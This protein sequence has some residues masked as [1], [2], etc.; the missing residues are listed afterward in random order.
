MPV[1][2]PNSTHT[3]QSTPR[4]R[5]WLPW[6]LLGVA[7]IAFATALFVL[8]P[9]SLWD[10]LTGRPLYEGRGVASWSKQ[11][12]STDS[13]A[14]A[15]AIFALSALGADAAS[16]VPV[17]ASI[18]EQDDDDNLRNQAAFALG[19]MA[20]ASRDAVPALAGAL[21]DANLTVRMTAAAALA[22]L[23][24]EAR[25]AIPALLEA[26]Q[27]DSNHTNLGKFLLTI[28]EMLVVALGRA[29][30]GTAE[31]VPALVRIVQSDDSEGLRAAA[32]R[33]LGEVGEEAR[34]TIPLLKTLL[35]DNSS[36]VRE[37][38]Q[39]ALEQLGEPIDELVAVQQSADLELPESERAW[40]WQVEN[41]GNELV[42]HGFGPLAQALEKADRQ[43]LSRLLADTFVGSDLAQVQSARLQRDFAEISRQRHSKTAQSLDRA[44]FVNRLLE[45][46]GRFTAEAP[47]VGL[48]LK[49]L[50][51][52]Q[53]EQLNGAWQGTAQMRLAGEFTTDKPGEIVVQLRFQL[54]QLTRQA[55]SK[56]GWL[57][58]VTIDEVTMAGATHRLFAEVA[59]QRGLQVEKLHDNWNAHKHAPVTGGI[60]V[61]DFNRDGFLDVLL[62]DLNGCLLYR[63]KAN[64]SFEEVTAAYGVPQAPPLSNAIA[65]VDL[66]GDGWEDLLL[67]DRLFRNQQGRHFEEV[68]RQCNLR[69]PADVSGVVVADY[70]RDGKLDLYATRPG[71]PGGKSWLDSHSADSLG[72]RLYRNKGNWQFEDVT[73]ATGAS[74]NRRST[75]T[76]A[77][78]DANGDGW[79]DL[80]VPNEF[81]DGVLLLNH[82]GTF[83]P[84]A[85]AD[86]PADFG[87]MGLAVGD[88]NNDGTI[89]LYCANMF[90]KAGTR[91]IGNLRPDA[92]PPAVLQKMRR[93]VAGSQL[94]L[95]RGNLKFEQVG[96]ALQLAGVGWAY[97]ACLA[98]LDNDG[99]L[100]IYATAGYISRS[101]TEPDG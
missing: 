42:K 77:W 82:K 61:T 23:G 98:D 81:G 60:Y 65:W 76:A 39:S 59:R 3:P 15:Q 1:S 84:I 93:F 96:Q 94:H 17:L 50:Q 52:T 41:R 49:T 89:D 57:G 101:R 20:P 22:R 9:L 47:R 64:G 4:K 87:T 8:S 75:F 19:K 35:A 63:G 40:L 37:A 38:A 62:T 30:I 73:R 70:D 46:R 100:D 78:L 10:Y 51:P 91:V 29:S 2:Q 55:L 58:S 27:D 13:E 28:Q 24:Q 66:D 99:W 69:I 21:K 83:R 25:P 11:L 92:F 68:T 7:L 5:R 54:P 67:G 34:S 80:H 16:A 33:A 88:V 85:L 44:A 31:A 48:S 90:S 43:A 74:G 71:K 45:W 72:N 18:L 36:F 53:R 14:K 26:L 12:D 97:G 95:N 79:P 6:L 56:P 86:V 32:T